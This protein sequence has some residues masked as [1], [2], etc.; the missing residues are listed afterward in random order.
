MK[1]NIGWVDR[2]ITGISSDDNSFYVQTSISNSSQS[3]QTKA[4]YENTEIYILISENIAL[5]D[6]LLS[7]YVGYIEDIATGVFEKSKNTKIGI[8]GMNGTINDSEIIDGI[9]VD[10]PNNE[11]TVNGT[12]DNAQIVSTP[13]DDVE[14]LK[15]ALLNINSEQYN[16]NVN[17]EAA[18]SLAKL[19]FSENTNKL[20]ISLYEGVPSIANGICRTVSY[21]G[22]FAE[23]STAEAAVIGQHEKIVS[24]TKKEILDLENHGVD[25]I[26]IRPGDTSYDQKWYSTSTGELTLEF[27][28]SPYVNELYGTLEDPIYGKSYSLEDTTFEEVINTNILEDIYEMIVEDIYNIEYIDTFDAEFLEIFDIELVTQPNYGT[29]NMDNIETENVVT[30]NIDRL[31]GETS[32]TMNYKFSLK[33]GYDT[34]VIG[35]VLKLNESSNISYEDFDG[36]VSEIEI[37]ETLSVKLSYVEIDSDVDGDV[38][39]DL[40]G[41]SDTDEVDDTV[42]TTV[43]PNTGNVVRIMIFL[44]LVIFAIY[45]YVKIRNLR[46]VK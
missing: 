17:L 22:M 36:N 37:D 23:Y 2:E 34:S 9:K 28:G 11:G 33:E 31:S 21:G 38:N 20:L 39:V 42:A 19:S 1:V 15:E 4:V 18:V 46:D 12:S 27:D 44:S 14:E 24:Y 6:E 29:V 3:E 5:D 7:D 35:E 45:K 25:L 43:L 40:D 30:W 32:A 13:T 8:I 41:D 10:G 16:Y 26:Q